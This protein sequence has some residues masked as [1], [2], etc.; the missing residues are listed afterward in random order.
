MTFLHKLCLASILALLN[1]GASYQP[2][3]AQVKINEVF[4]APS[5]GPEWVEL[6]NPTAE[7]INLSGWSL[8]D[9]L[10]SPSVIHTFGAG[11]Q[12]EP[13]SFLVIELTSA[14]LNNAA[15]GVTL[16][17]AVT[18][19]VDTMTYSSSSTNQ[20]WA[21]KPDGIGSFF[22]SE[23]SK[24]LTNG[25]PPLPSPSPSPSPSPQPSPS[26]TTH[27]TP[28]PSPSPIPEFFQVEITE[29][30]ACPASGDTEWI[31]LY[32]PHDQAKTLTNWQVRDISNTS[33]VVSTTI[34]AHSYGVLSWSGSLLN[35]TGDSFSLLDSQNRVVATASHPACKTGTS[36]IWHNDTWQPTNYPTKG[37]ANP[38]SAAESAPASTTAQSVLGE[39]DEFSNLLPTSH[40]LATDTLNAGPLTS[41]LHPPPTTT[42]AAQLLNPANFNIS[43][44]AYNP[45]TNPPQIIDLS[46]P[47]T[48]KWGVVNVILGGALLTAAGSYLVYETYRIENPV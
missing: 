42:Q 28:Q 41:S 37:A 30:M 14:K 44:P 39:D 48:S 1:L 17:N 25:T 46:Q 9:H 8:E 29:I 15:D 2:A 11:S 43:A 23:P 6:Y 33:K 3:T 36:F 35:N 21:R 32:N 13:E 19:S 12:I 40:P 31:E 16:K 4:P 22:L 5:D 47:M 10:T 7:T 26:L 27:P 34:P 18:E 24:G 45:I 20:S 38:T